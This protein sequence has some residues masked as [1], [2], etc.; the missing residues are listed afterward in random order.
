MACPFPKT[1]L[2]ARNI[3]LS[4][5]SAGRRITLGV[6]LNMMP[7]YSRTA[8]LSINRGPQ[9]PRGG[10]GFFQYKAFTMQQSVGQIT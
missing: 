9:A 1:A 10:L 3:R 8:N 7:S 5:K 6:R 4:S 2:R